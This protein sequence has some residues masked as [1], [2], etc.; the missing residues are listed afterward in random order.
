MKS[1]IRMCKINYFK[2]MQWVLYMPLILPLCFV[3]GLFYG[4][5][6]LAVFVCEDVWQK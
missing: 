6:R 5:Y 2:L 1:G 3:V 4:I